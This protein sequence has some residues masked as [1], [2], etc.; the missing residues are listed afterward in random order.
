MKACGCSTLEIWA[1]STIDDFAGSHI[2]PGILR[3]YDATT[4]A[5]LWNS[6]AIPADSLGNWAKFVPPVIANGK[7][8]VASFSNSIVVYGVN[9]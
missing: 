1:A 3:A 4:L 8:Y 2:V 7:V 9:H 5:D 6:E